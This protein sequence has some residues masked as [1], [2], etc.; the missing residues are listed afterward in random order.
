MVRILLL[1][2]DPELRQGYEEI[3]HL[4]EHEVD[5][6]STV[7]EAETALRTRE[8]DAIFTDYNLPDGKGVLIAKKALAKG[9]SRVFLM[10]SATLESI[11]SREGK[12]P[13]GIRYFP[14]IPS[15]TLCLMMEDPMGEIF[16]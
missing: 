4:A 9:I 1:E 10:S 13:H 11:E 2:D 3:M 16:I 5:S 6:F 14:K 7:A 12:L 15:H 8:Y